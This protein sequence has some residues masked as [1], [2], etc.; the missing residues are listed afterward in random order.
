MNEEDR[1]DTIDPSHTVVCTIT[2]AV[3]VVSPN[4]IFI[5]ET[6]LLK[7]RLCQGECNT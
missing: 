6:I 5:E 7:C 2:P 1:D 3:Y 4:S